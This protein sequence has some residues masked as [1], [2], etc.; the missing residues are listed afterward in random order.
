MAPKSTPTQDQRPKIKVQRP[1]LDQFQPTKEICNLDCRI[2]VRIRAMRSILAD[3]CAEFF[4]ECSFI[5]LRRIGCSHQIAPS[6]HRTVFLQHHDDARCARH[7]FSKTV[8]ERLA[9]MNFIKA[10]GLLPRLMNHLHPSNAKA[11]C[12][13]AIYDLPSMARADRVRLDDCE[14][15]VPRMV[16]HYMSAVYSAICLGISDRFVPGWRLSILCCLHR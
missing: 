15:Q 6:L 13:D 3:R 7:E 12:D 4:A 2:V 14:C 16:S 5:G 9:A 8:I 1:S 10:F 11:A